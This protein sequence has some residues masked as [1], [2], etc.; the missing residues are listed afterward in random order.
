[1]G[2]I[3]QIGG[4]IMSGNF[5]GAL[6][7]LGSDIMGAP[8]WI[9]Q[10]LGGLGNIFSGGATG[11]PLAGSPAASP[12]G[13]GQSVPNIVAGGG[14]GSPTGALSLASDMNFGGGASSS[15]LDQALGTGWVD[16]SLSGPGLNLAPLGGPGP[17]AGGAGSSWTNQLLPAA[18]TAYSVYRGNQG[19]PG[20]GA[21]RSLAGQNSNLGTTL[22]R[23][24]IE[25][26]QGHLPGSAE[27][28]IQ[29]GLAAA[30]AA[31]QSRYAGM[32]LTGSTME[33]QDLA[34]AEMAATAQRFTI[35]NQ[36]AATGLS[37]AFNADTLATELYSQIMQ[38]EIAQ[39][40]ELGNAL[41]GFAGASVPAN[42]VTGG[43]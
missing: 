33:A 29:Q 15:A 11:Q 34:N 17:V 43:P 30:K 16:T 42:P 32:G 28:G 9:G 25:E 7:H 5:G 20:E 8:G 10:Q 39:G 22:S 12:A 40:T 26:M 37:A 27:Q 38:G 2:G 14:S 21:M 19:F 35:G 4:D 41:A 13:F 24:A 31:I 36:M 1:M 6:G 23:G 3:G 18:M